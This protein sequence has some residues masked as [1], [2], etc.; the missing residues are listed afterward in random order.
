MEHLWARFG[1]NASVSQMLQNNPEGLPR[2]S[3]KE[4][5]ERKEIIRKQIQLQSIITVTYSS[6][7][8]LIAVH[9]VPVLLNLK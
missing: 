4:V 2:Q 6:K 3:A 8:V 9:T 1:K 5:L 7:N